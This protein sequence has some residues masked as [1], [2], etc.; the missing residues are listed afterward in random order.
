MSGAFAQ[1]MMTV[2]MH[3]LAASLLK[4]PDNEGCDPPISSIVRNG[5]SV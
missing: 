5:G 3:N 2:K 1:D 4:Q